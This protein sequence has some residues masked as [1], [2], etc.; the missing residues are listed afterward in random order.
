MIAFKRCKGC[1]MIPHLKIL[2]Q[3]LL[4]ELRKTMGKMSKQSVSM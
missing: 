2:T 1:G 4:G 3:Y